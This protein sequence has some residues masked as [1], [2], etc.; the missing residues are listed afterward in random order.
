M[1]S[2]NVFL[3]LSALE[4]GHCSPVDSAL[5]KFERFVEKY[6]KIYA[7]IE[8]RQAHF[9]T[10]KT[11]VAFI[12]AE[13]SRQT[14]YTL[15]VN[16][17]AD[18][19]GEDFG[20]T[21][22]GFKAPEHPAKHLLGTPYLGAHLY[23]GEPLPESVDW[24]SSGG[25]VTPVKDQASCGSCWTFSAT[26]ALE[27]AWQIATGQLVAISEQQLV[28]CAKEGGL[29]GCNG[30]EM[31]P[32]FTY[33]EQHVACTEDSYP[34]KH[35]DGECAETTCIEAI[36]KGGVLGYKDVPQDTQAL[37]EAVAQQPV[38]TAVQAGRGA[39]SM[40]QSGIVTDECTAMVDHA[41][42]IVGYGTEN[43]TDYWKIKNSWGSDW[44]EHGFIRLARGVADKGECGVKVM[45]T[46]PVVRQIDMVV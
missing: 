42:L 26:G 17:F 36:P 28:D 20:S 22:L 30:G 46:Y 12:E 8:Q 45:P 25:A 2:F 33:L 37:M 18:A 11:N 32:A 15:A 40:Y 1:R 4:S 13:N 34:Y 43:A 9:E 39:F 21:R 6:G 41:V 23:S 14:S 44:G 27:G 24:F 29:D 19:S 16:A 10:F 3:A 31:D 5:T 35:E 7:S 38:S